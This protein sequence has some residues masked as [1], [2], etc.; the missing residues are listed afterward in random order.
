MAP[1]PELDEVLERAERY[2]S[3]NGIDTSG[4]GLFQEHKHFAC[5][6]S[7]KAGPIIDTD[8]TVSLCRGREDVYVGNIHESDINEKWQRFAEE[9][10]P[11]EWCSYCQYRTN[12]DGIHPLP[13]TIRR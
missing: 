6:L 7:G 1:S 4:I 3:T 2:L 11:A 5:Y 12:S 8:G 10:D 9:L 13:S